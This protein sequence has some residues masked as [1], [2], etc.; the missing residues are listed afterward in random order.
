MLEKIAFI[1]RDEL[2][3]NFNIREKYFV[4]L[5]EKQGIKATVGDKYTRTI[6]FNL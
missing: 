1:M 3:I 4:K 5:L 6:F 2:N